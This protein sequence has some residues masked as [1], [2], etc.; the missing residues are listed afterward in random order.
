MN[1]LENLNEKLTFFAD[2][3]EKKQEKKPFFS[4]GSVATAVGGL[5]LGV[6]SGIAGKTYPLM[7]VPFLKKPGQKVAHYIEGANATM[8]TGL[9]GMGIGA[10]IKQHHNNP[11][12]IVAKALKKTIGDDFAVSHYARFRGGPHSALEHWH[13][14]YNWDLVHKFKNKSGTL[15][16]AHFD[17]TLKV[18]LNPKEAYS[19]ADPE[20][21]AKMRAKL[22]SRLSKSN[23]SY[24]A[25][26]DDM[27]FLQEHKG[28]SDLEALHAVSEMPHHQN[29]F[30]NLVA[31]KQA[32][33][34][35]YAKLSAAA[36][37]GT[38]AVGLGGMALGYHQKKG[39]SE[40]QK[41]RKKHHLSAKNKNTAQYATALK[42]LSAKRQRVIEFITR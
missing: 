39:A 26:K 6:A 34:P 42:E 2:Q 19:G 40:T 4:P 21:Y 1:L 33:L 25:V 3:Q 31:N 17:K 15:A 37:A 9:T 7:R 11:N 35:T 20:Q 32:A 8:N 12:G 22:D 28:H 36:T 38:G 30:R 23:A 27:A 18:K 10:A 41:E 14:E 13:N 5:G 29:Y 16:D 24:Q